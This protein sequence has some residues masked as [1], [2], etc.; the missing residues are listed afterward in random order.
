MLGLQDW[1]LPSNVG[2]ESLLQVHGLAK[3][4][5]E[6]NGPDLNLGSS[7]LIRDKLQDL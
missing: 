7:S 6:D 1:D 3:P 2:I 5:D 4:A